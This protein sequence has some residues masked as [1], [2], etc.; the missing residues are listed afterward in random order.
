[1]LLN[2]DLSSPYFI[3]QK[4]DICIFIFN[5]TCPTF[6]FN[7]NI[8]KILILL[9]RQN[10]VR[11]LHFSSRSIL[12]FSLLLLLIRFSEEFKR[13]KRFLLYQMLMRS[14][15]KRKREARKHQNTLTLTSFLRN[16][17]IHIIY[18]FRLRTKLFKTIIYSP[19][20]FLVFRILKINNIYEFNIYQVYNIHFH[21]YF[22]VLNN[23]S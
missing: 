20:A 13:I 23:L 6:K 3:L 2:G 5:Y 9:L 22:V 14:L 15:E 17:G 11:V 8:Q 18:T 10:D 16:S 4:I 19:F 12:M 1:M 7:F 21:I